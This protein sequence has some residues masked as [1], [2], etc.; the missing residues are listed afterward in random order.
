[1][2]KPHNFIFTND[3]IE[4]I[5]NLYRRYGIPMEEPFL[6]CAEGKL[7]E[8]FEHTTGIKVNK[9]ISFSTFNENANYVKGKVSQFEQ[10][11][12]VNHNWN[13]VTIKWQSK[14][15]RIYGVDDKDIDCADLEVWIEGLDIPLI[16]RQLYPKQEL[17]FK[18][19]ELTYELIVT[20]INVDC[21]IE[22]D[23]EP[24]ADIQSV[25]SEIDAFI[26]GFNEKSEQKD[27]EHGVVH[28]WKSRSNG[29]KLT[30]EL[31]L[32]STGG[33]FMKKFL[34]HLSN[35]AVFDRV[36]IC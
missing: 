10:Y 4:T 13:L 24:N 17:P 16:H 21:T 11:M 22:M 28:N 23:L 31:D 8:S 30:F 12:Y 33:Y 5:L 14:S 27:R 35:M 25:T 7:K 9:H 36:E 3:T 34:V 20:R 29:R 15:G 19:K 26:G 1:M 6:R 32:G 18:L 2:S